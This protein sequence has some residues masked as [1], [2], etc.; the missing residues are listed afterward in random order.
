MVKKILILLGI[1]VIIVAGISYYMWNMPRHIPKDGIKITAV[2]LVKEYTANDTLSNK[3]Y[4]GK[5]LEITGEVDEIDKKNGLNVTL[6][7]SDPNYVVSCKMKDSTIVLTKSQKVTIVGFC[8]GF[9][10]DPIFGAVNCTDC[11][12]KK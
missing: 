7:T 8:S 2:D 5:S 10:P 6:K 3:K 1:V 12:I 9:I 11:S 4:L